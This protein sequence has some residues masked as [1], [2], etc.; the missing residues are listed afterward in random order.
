MG[1]ELPHACEEV[2]PVPEGL[3]AQEVEREEGLQDLPC[4]GVVAALAVGISQLRSARI[5]LTFAQFSQRLES[6]L[7]LAHR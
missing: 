2:L 7:E 4:R 5:P 6:E 3:E 1:E